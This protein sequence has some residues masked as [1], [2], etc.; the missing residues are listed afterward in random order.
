[1][2]Q[3]RGKSFF[4]VPYLTVPYMQTDRLMM[5]MRKRKRRRRAISLITYAH[6]YT[7]Y[8]TVRILSWVGERILRKGGGE[9]S[10]QQQQEHLIK[11][12]V[13]L[14]QYSTSVYTLIVKER[15]RERE[16]KS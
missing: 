13:S 1:M 15:E 14:F 2:Q 12:A 10:N 7:L 5:M 11:L 6:C 8:C 16:E 9:G 4:Y 3:K